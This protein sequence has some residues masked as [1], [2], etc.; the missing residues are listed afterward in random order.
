MNGANGNDASSKF[1][2]ASRLCAESE[3]RQVSTLLYTLG[4]DAED[5]LSSTN[6]SEDN[7]KKYTEVMA[8]LDSFFQVRKNV[9]CERAR[10]NRRLQLADES[11]E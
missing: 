5:V 3:E 1:C 2:L 4:E 11:V 8:K 10:F 9:I 6:I 7:R